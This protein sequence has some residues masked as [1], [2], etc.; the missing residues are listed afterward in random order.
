MPTKVKYRYTSL[1]DFLISNPLTVDGQLDDGGGFEFPVKGREIHASILFAD[2]SSFSKRTLELSPTE[3]LIFVNNFFTWITAEAL[4]GRP[5]IVD[6]YI[7][8]EMMVIFSEEFGSEDSFVDALQTARWMAENDA[9]SFCPHMGI[10]AGIVTVGYVGT[11]LKYSCSVFGVP[12]VVAK[13]CAS[14]KPQS[15]GHSSIFFPADLWMDRSF[16]KIFPLKKLKKS[17]GRVVEQPQTWKLLP[18]RKVSMKNMPDIE[19]LEV[20]RETIFIPQESA[21]ERAKQALRA[22]QEAGMYRPQV[23]KAKE[24]V[25]NL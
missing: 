18:S 2:I 7:G 11:P 24:N 25:E 1:E 19:I 23:A 9:L 3:T 5:G 17:D 21:E 22:L 12:I 6:K 4:R 15:P 10:A 20:T 16:E 13:R 14:I 8:D